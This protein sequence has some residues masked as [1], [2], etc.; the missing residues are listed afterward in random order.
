MALKTYYKHK[1]KPSLTKDKNKA[2][3][4]TMNLFEFWKHAKFFFTS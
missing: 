1:N 3:T 2:E 4:M